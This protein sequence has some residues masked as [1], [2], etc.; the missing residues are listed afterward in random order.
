MADSL[1]AMKYALA[2]RPTKQLDEHGLYSRAAEVARQLPQEKG[3][4]QQMLAMI[5]KAKGVK[6]DEIKYSDVQNAYAD[7]PTVSRDELAKYFEQERPR[8]TIDESQAKKFADYSTKGGEGYRANVYAMTSPLAF[9]GDRPIFQPRL[10]WDTTNP[11]VHHRTKEFDDVESVKATKPKIPNPDKTLSIFRKDTR[12][13]EDFPA[14]ST[15]VNGLSINKSLDNPKNYN[16]THDHSGL[17][18]SRDIPTF[19]GAQNAVKIWAY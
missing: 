16:I 14:W 4:P 17:V 3:T 19:H 5:A 1:D 7:Y 6:P 18:V 15:G 12:D 11:V 13:R 8:L 2:M 10:H 9:G